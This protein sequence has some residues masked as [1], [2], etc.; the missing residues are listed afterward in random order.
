MAIHTVMG[1]QACCDGCGKEYGIFPSLVKAQETV[2]NDKDWKVIEGKAYCPKCAVNPPKLTQKE[3]EE[4]IYAAKQ[5]LE[6]QEK[7]STEVLTDKIE[8]K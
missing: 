7:N 3:F 5:Y 1:Y 8:K 6:Y 2:K 4:A